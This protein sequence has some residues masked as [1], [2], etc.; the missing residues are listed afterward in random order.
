MLGL[1]QREYLGNVFQIERLGYDL[2]ARLALFQHAN[3]LES[4]VN[5]AIRSSVRVVPGWFF[6]VLVAGHAILTQPGGRSGLPAE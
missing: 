5:T 2:F 6:D 4:R 3:I 1:L